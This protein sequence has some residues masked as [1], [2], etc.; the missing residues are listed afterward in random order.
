[1]TTKI[2]R[3]DAEL[4]QRIAG[5]AAHERLPREVDLALALDVSRSTLRQALGALQRSGLIY[6]IPGSGTFVSDR[7]V[8]KGASLSGFSDDMR[9]R[10]MEPGSRLLSATPVVVTAPVAT[11]LGVADGELA[12][13]IDRLRLADREPMCIES[14]LLPAT[15]FPGL[16]RHDLTGGLY[17]LLRTE[18]GVEVATAQQSVSAMTAS[19]EQRALL[20]IEEGDPLLAVHRV[21]LDDRGQIVERAVSHYRADRYSFMLIATR[22]G[23]S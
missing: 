11:E 9:A 21:G 4:R 17:D 3:I 10:G 2:R 23:V 22:E 6:T 14:V 18:Y 20:G 12:Y 19:A 13:S 8:T 16:L 15:L 7:R 1:V 5:M